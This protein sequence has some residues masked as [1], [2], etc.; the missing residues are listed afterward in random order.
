MTP[1]ESCE[2]RLL[3]SAVAGLEN[4]T[5]STRC[6]ENTAGVNPAFALGCEQCGGALYEPVT[7]ENGRTCCL[8][9]A[10]KCDRGPAS[11]PPEVGYGSHVDVLLSEVTRDCFPRAYA[12]AAARQA[13]NALF[14][15]RDYTGACEAYTAALE[16]C[17]TEAVLL[18][19]RAAAWLALDKPDEAVNDSA[20]AASLLAVVPGK[21]LWAKAWFRRGQALLECPKHPEA[22]PEAVYALSLAAAGMAA[23]A[24]PRSPPTQLRAAIVA[25]LETVAGD[26]DPASNPIVEALCSR[27]ASTPGAA[28]GI[29]GAVQARGLAPEE[30]V[31]GRTMTYTYS[32]PESYLPRL[33]EQLECPL[34]CSLLHEPATTPCGHT[35]CRVCLARLLDHAFDVAPKCPLCRSKLAIYLCWLNLRAIAEGRAGCSDSQGSKQIVLNRAG[36]HLLR[37]HFPGELRDRGMQVGDEEA[38]TCDV[39]ETSTPIFIC[40]LALPGVACPLH[41]F[42][43]RYRLM[44]R[45]CLDS[46]HRQF[47]MCYTPDSEFGTILR[48]ERFDQLAD[49]RSL[50]KTVGSQRFRVLRWGQK[51]GYAT[52]IVEWIEDH[53]ECDSDSV[54]A[55]LLCEKIGQFISTVVTPNNRMQRV[56]EQIGDRPPPQDTAAALSFWSLAL[57]QVFSAIDS[58]IAYAVAF[59]DKHRHSQVQRLKTMLA[60]WDQVD[61][62][63]AGSLIVDLPETESEEGEEE[64]EERI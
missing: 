28:P 18:C 2:A 6:G 57:L 49:G 8:P 38:T 4:L 58:K 13:A 11:A 34:C 7:L 51:D 9:C 53:D 21:P 36:E 20:R 31:T 45:R 59:D 15:K 61:L 64:E 14:V 30:Q 43:P 26:G 54:Q 42:E 27:L 23:Q 25:L 22:L 55:R 56:C 1:V 40:S 39:S 44:I 12:A 50:V 16:Q 37:R 60:L 63:N 47:G 24:P 52:G 41:I 29:E 10:P 3:E 33:R 5:L 32:V 62:A 17:P 48:I 19:N 46:G 35:F